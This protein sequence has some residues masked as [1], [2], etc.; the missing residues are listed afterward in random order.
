MRFKEREQKGIIYGF[1]LDKSQDGFCKAFAKST[2][3]SSSDEAKADY[4]R[5][6][7]PSEFFSDLYYKFSKNPYPNLFYIYDIRDIRDDCQ[8]SIKTMY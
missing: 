3:S 1:P 8:D 6:H 5:R 7:Y 4:G 2:G